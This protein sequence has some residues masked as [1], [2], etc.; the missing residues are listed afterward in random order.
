MVD[1]AIYCI[2]LYILGLIQYI[3]V[4]TVISQY[5]YG[6][7]GYV[8]IRQYILGQKKLKKLHDLENQT[9][10]LMQAL[11][12]TALRPIMQYQDSNWR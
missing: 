12:T 2:V 8:R 9:H 1:T 5:N 3:S 11:Y 10:D 4:C 7:Q 6:Q